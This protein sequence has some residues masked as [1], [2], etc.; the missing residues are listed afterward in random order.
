MLLL[1]E[2]VG[3]ITD[4]QRDVLNKAENSVRRLKGI[5]DDLLD[6]ARIET[7]RLK[8]HY[9]LVNLNDLLKES[10]DFFNKQAQNKGI[11]LEYVLPK[12]QVNIFLIITG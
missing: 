8:L 6:V 12:E 10:A 3:A 5:I 2:V 11:S 7:G 9:S 1:D 4:K